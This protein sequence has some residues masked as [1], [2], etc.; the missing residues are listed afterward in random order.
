VSDQSRQTQYVWTRGGY[1]PSAVVLDIDQIGGKAPQQGNCESVK[2]TLVPR[3]E[4]KATPDTGYARWL[5]NGD[6]SSGLCRIE[7]RWKLGDAA[8]QQLDVTLS[9][10]SLVPQRLT[11]RGFGRLD[12]RVMGGLGVFR[13]IVRDIDIQCDSASQQKEC[14]HAATFPTKVTVTQR[15][16]GVEPY[17]AVEFPLIFATR[18][19]GPVSEFLLRRI[20]LAGGTTLK[21]PAR[22]PFAAIDVMPF[23]DPFLEGVPFQLTIGTTVSKHREF[24]YGVSVDATLITKPLV[25]I[26]GLTGS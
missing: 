13:N 14:A 24:F 3:L 18:F 2:F 16:N 12:P 22:N 7:T 19:T 26:F 1:V 17:G 5:P 15:R 21:H 8:N 25:G 4:G 11:T 10:K 6:A 20:R 23:V 9:G